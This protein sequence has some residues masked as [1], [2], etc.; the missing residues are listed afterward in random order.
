MFDVAKTF[1]IQLIGILP[2]VIPLILIMNL[3]CDMLFG[4]R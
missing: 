1:M 3:C 2:F 4:R